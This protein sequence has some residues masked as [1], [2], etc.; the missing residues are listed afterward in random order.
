MWYEVGF[1][2]PYSMCVQV[3]GQ[4]CGVSSLFT[5]TWVPESKPWPSSPLLGLSPE[6]PAP[7]NCRACFLGSPKAALWSDYNAMLTVLLCSVLSAMLSWSKHLYPNGLQHTSILLLGATMRDMLWRKVSEICLFNTAA[8][9]LENFIS[10]DQPCS[11]WLY[12]GD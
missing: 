2:V 8:A 1:F 6:V 11:L 5:F 4:L 3:R 12:Q 9:S 10:L 7:E